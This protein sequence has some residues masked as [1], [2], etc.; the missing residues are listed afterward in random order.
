MKKIFALLLAL[1]M[2]LAL[3]ACGGEKEASNG[4]SVSDSDLSEKV[5]FEI[6]DLEY[7]IYNNGVLSIKFLLGNLSEFDFSSVNLTYQVFDEEDNKVSTN[8]IIGFMSMHGESAWCGPATQQLKEG[9]T[10]G[11]IRFID[12][13]AYITEG[14]NPSGNIKTILKGDVLDNVFPFGSCTL[15]STNDDGNAV[16]A[17]RLSVGE[18]L[19]TDSLEITLKDLAFEGSV[20]IGSGI[21]IAASGDDMLLA[22]LY[23][24]IKNISKEPMLVRDV[25]D[26]KVDYNEGFIYNTQDKYCYLLEAKDNDPSVCTFKYDGYASGTEFKLSPLSSDKFLLAI[27]CAQAVSEDNTSPLKVVF[28]LPNGDTTQSYEYIIIE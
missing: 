24:D 22:C 25:L 14:N 5:T 28:T 21:S 27:P 2:V 9:Q 3:C 26:V 17:E 19:K 6:K 4:L 1:S 10:G 16:E 7:Q 23:F 11:Y 13:E 20:D 18:T 15:E 8:S 12:A